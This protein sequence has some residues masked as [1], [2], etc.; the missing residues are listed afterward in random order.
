MVHVKIC[1]SVKKREKPAFQAVSALF[2]ELDFD[3]VVHMAATLGRCSMDQAIGV[4]VQGTHKVLEACTAACRTK[5]KKCKIVVASSVAAIGTC[6]PHWPPT[7]VPVPATHGN[8]LGPWPYA[9]SKSQNE[10][11]CK[12]LATLPENADI[13]LDVIALRVGNVVTAPPDIVHHDGQGVEYP[14]KGATSSDV[15]DQLAV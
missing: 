14:V 4:N 1:P 6:A 10:E 13:D 11:Y 9:L 7:E 2:A 8:V 3:V 5:G 12:V 15:T